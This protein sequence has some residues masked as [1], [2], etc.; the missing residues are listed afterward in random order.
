MDP[1][2]AGLI[3]LVFALAPGYIAD[4]L[5]R[6]TWGISKGDNMD[7]VLRMAV[8]TAFGIALYTLFIGGPPNYL[9]II[10]ADDLAGRIGYRSFE[11]NRATFPALA[12][13]T[14]LACFASTT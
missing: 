13:H 8:W 12:I 7:R 10:I 1:D 2:K 3:G 5:F 9:P 11:F 4:L 14:V 6:A